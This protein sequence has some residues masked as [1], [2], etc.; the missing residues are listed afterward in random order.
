MEAPKLEPEQQATYKDVKK[1]FD[2]AHENI[3]LTM[4]KLKIKE[5]SIQTVESKLEE[6]KKELVE[7]RQDHNK[8]TDEAKRLGRQKDRLAR[9]LVPQ[10]P[11]ADVESVCSSDVGSIPSIDADEF[12]IDPNKPDGTDDFSLK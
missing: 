3:D 6:A 10:A 12:P 5:K 2:L 1:Q 7:L 4:N 8:Y 9:G 11:E